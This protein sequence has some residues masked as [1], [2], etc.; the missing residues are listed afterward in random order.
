MAKS[1]HKIKTT[2]SQEKK[3][4]QMSPFEIKNTLID[5]ANKHTDKSTHAMLNAGRGNPNWI[6]TEPRQA[7]FTLGSFGVEECRRG[8]D[9][10][11]G[12]AGIPVK[13]G[14]A[15]RFRLFLADSKAPGTALLRELYEYAIKD[16]GFDPDI[17][18]HEITEGIIGDQY[19]VPD[20]ILSSC[21]AIVHDYLVQEMCEN[22]PPKGKYEL[23]ATE[24]G[25]AAMCYIFDSLMQNFLVK[26]GDKIAL[27]VPTFTPYIE[28]P[29]LD[30]YHF[31][32]VHIHASGK[33][34]EGFHQWDYPDR[35]LDKLKDPDIKV[36]FLV[37]PSN[38]PSYALSDRE[39]K[40]II[41]I[42]EKDN[43][44]LMFI[45]DD[46]Y[47]TFVNGFRSL[48]A[49]IPHNTLGVYSFSKYFGC[50]GWRLGVIALHEKNIYDQKIKALPDNKKKALNKRYG[51]ITLKPEKLK[52]IDRMVADSRSVALNHTAG[53][54]L[55]QQMQ[56]MLFAA[57]ALFDKKNAYKQ[58]TQK[59]VQKRYDMLF[60][61]IGVKIKP[62]PN[63][64]GYYA[65]IDLMIWARKEY[66]KEFTDYL[67]KN[68]EPVDILFRLAEL[69]S[70]VL[71]NG[72][73]F[74][75]PE[76]S[77]RVSLANLDED[78]YPAIG[79][80]IKQLSE[81]YVEEWKANK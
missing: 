23:F 12:L 47:G 35:E 42:V 55:P 56:M 15:K 25:T 58:L 21:N 66:G 74:D 81:E 19:P 8:M 64:A 59:I 72:G 63:R 53:L 22:K 41:Q 16:H 48:M 6:A 5:L 75:G 17:F 80:A 43:P 78:A 69:C 62:N 70:I 34:G 27:F 26:R 14:I 13:D 2:R 60:D 40:R 10:K 20:R 54:S 50:T 45:T 11:E 79:K 52:F 30:R 57:F 31:K 73:G 77:I 9:Y 4:E 24:G 29:E 37:N 3:L 61:G 46:V 51:S 18:V 33:T 1:T 36:A 38:P 44:G 67:R 68:Y 76:W 39:R 32:V 49:E 7:F 28:I 71:L 65:E